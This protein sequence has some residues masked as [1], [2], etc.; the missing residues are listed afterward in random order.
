MLETENKKNED[1]L[2]R[3][4]KNTEHQKERND[5]LTAA[6]KRYIKEINSLRS[7]QRDVFKSSHQFHKDTMNL[8]NKTALAKQQDIGEKFEVR[9][10]E[11]TKKQIA[12]EL[13][14]KL[15]DLNLMQILG[16]TK[17]QDRFLQSV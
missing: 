9:T 16:V 8:I 6:M 11:N 5:T 1:K 14:Q 13:L 3:S 4:E 2:G 12:N 10:E 17:Q 7:S 15:E